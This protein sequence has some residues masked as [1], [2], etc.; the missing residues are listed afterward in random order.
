M[1]DKSISE[2]SR[3]R[4]RSQAVNSMYNFF[5]SC[6]IFCL[7]LFVLPGRRFL[8]LAMSSTAN[9]S[10]VCLQDLG[11]LNL[12]LYVSGFVFLFFTTV[13]L[14][15]NLLFGGGLPFCGLYRS[16]TCS[17]TLEV[18]ALSRRLSL[19]TIRPLSF[20]L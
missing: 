1:T 20:L 8:M 17:F 13:P 15:T 11:G 4:K 2:K 16:R 3:S 9:H 5:R 12:T 18:S 19:F 6:F 14:T 7:Y 10:S